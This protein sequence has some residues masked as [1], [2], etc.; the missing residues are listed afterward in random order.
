M[1]VPWLRALLS[2]RR[3]NRVA[4]PS[5]PTI[6]AAQR[7]AVCHWIYDRLDG[8]DDLRLVA[9]RDPREAAR[10]GREFEVYL[11]LLDND[12][13]WGEGTG[14]PVELTT[15]PSALRDAFL[16]MLHGVSRAQ[17][18]EARDRAEASVEA[19]AF[20]R[21]SDLLLGACREVLTTLDGNGAPV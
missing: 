7:D 10:L 13:G 2:S 12:L 4:V 6:S 17:A 16:T 9:R 14:E 1:R 15:S 8:V 18:V 21:Q 11:A 20:A 5:Y 19:A 3:R